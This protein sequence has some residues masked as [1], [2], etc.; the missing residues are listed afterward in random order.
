MHMN[1]CTRMENVVPVK[2]DISNYYESIPG[3]SQSS[4][5][6]ANSGV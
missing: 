1:D 4:S 3:G 6:K 2:G 5:I